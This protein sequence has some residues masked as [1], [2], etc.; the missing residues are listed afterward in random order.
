LEC[1][2]RHKIY[3]Y[4]RLPKPYVYSNREDLYMILK[5][6]LVLSNLVFTKHQ[7]NI[8]SINTLTVSCWPA[9][10]SSTTRHHPKPP[11]TPFPLHL[12]RTLLHPQPEDLIASDFDPTGPETVRYI[13]RLHH[14]ASH[15]FLLH[16]WPA[17]PMSSSTPTATANRSYPSMAPAKKGVVGRYDTTL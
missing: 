14:L 7:N 9:P 12:P 4:P 16:A 13:P 11:T 3:L 10:P 8:K 5:K 1:K 6:M 15:A 2:T 17:S